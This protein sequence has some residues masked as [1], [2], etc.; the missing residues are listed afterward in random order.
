MG[1]LTDALLPGNRRIL[2]NGV[3]PSR[4]R[5][6]LEIACLGATVADDEGRQLT[7]VSFPANGSGPTEWAFFIPALSAS[8]GSFAIG[9]GSFSAFWRQD[10]TDNIQIAFLLNVGSTTNFGTGN[11]QIDFNGGP[12]LWIDSEK[13]PGTPAG[14]LTFCSVE[15]RDASTPANNRGGSLDFVNEHT[16]RI[17]PYGVAGPL[18]ATVPFTWANGDQIKFAVSLPAHPPPV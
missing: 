13:L 14:V 2:V 7:R 15:L 16:L 18:T 10:S 8:G 11:F 1:N 6:T 9:N 17:L 3:S 12:F 4:G 5:D